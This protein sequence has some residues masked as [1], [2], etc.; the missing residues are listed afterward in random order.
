MLIVFFFT[1]AGAAL[2]MH[3]FSNQGAC[4]KAALVA[5]AATHDVKKGSQVW[6]YCVAK[7]EDNQ[8]REAEQPSHGP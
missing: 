7:G 6:A 2:D 3:D 8:P 5:Q 1:G 4:E